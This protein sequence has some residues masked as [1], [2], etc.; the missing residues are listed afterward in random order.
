QAQRHGHVVSPV[1]GVHLVDEP[2]PLLRERQRDL[3]ISPS[4]LYLF[5]IRL[6]LDPTHLLGRCRHPSNRGLFKQ[7]SQGH[8]HPKLTTYSRYQLRPQQRM[9]T[10]IEEVVGHSNRLDPQQVLPEIGKSPFHFCRGWN[11]GILQRRPFMFNRREVNSSSPFSLIPF[12]SE[13]VLSLTLQIIRRRNRH[14]R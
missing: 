5:P 8:F 6:C 4:V 3:R 1:A 12:Q 2:Q 7:H 14:L 11:K 10:Q 9:T 13:F